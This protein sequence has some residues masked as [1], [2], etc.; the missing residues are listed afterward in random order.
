MRYLA[1]WRG[2]EWDNE[3]MVVDTKDDA[4]VITGLTQATAKSIV[5]V[6]NFKHEGRTNE[7]N[8]R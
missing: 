7:Y 4:T 6:L 2:E 1:E 8:T 3:W 5:H